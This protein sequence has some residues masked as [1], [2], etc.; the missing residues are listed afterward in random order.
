[1]RATLFQV[2]HQQVDKILKFL[3]ALPCGLF[4]LLIP[5]LRQ[6]FAWRDQFRTAEKRRKESVNCFEIHGV[7]GAKTVKDRL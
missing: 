2:T 4:G 5:N 6:V 3:F 1:M 7:L